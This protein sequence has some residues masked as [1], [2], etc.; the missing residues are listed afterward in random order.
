MELQVVQHP[1]SCIASFACTSSKLKPQAFA[2]SLPDSA[3]LLVS[4]KQSFNFHTHQKIRCAI[5]WGTFHMLLDAAGLDAQTPAKSGAELGRRTPQGSGK[6]ALRTARHAGLM[7]R[8]QH[9][10]RPSPAAPAQAQHQ[11]EVTDWLLHQ[12][13][14]VVMLCSY[15]SRGDSEV[16]ACLFLPF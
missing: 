12:L 5:D 3:F 6:P 2:N 7:A 4:Q 15:S 13:H 10:G 14:N 11:T 1:D 16:Q 9:H 8:M